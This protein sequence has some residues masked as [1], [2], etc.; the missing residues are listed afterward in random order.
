[1]KLILSGGG[2]AE[3]TKRLDEFFVSLIPG[4]RK[5]L[6]IPIAMKLKYDTKECLDWLKKCLTKGLL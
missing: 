6:Y 1:M 2:D 3:Q 4:G 5:I